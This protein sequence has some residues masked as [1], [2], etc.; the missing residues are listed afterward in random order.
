MAKNQIIGKVIA[1]S[2]RQTIQ[3]K[4][5]TKQPVVK[6]QLYMDCTRFDPYT[7]ERGY[8]N[9][10]LLEFANRALEKL[11]ALGLNKGDVVTVT[12]DIQG[13]R[14]KD[15]TGKP[16]IFTRV[17]PYDIELTRRN[18]QPAAPQ[19]QAPLPEPPVKEHV[20]SNGEALIF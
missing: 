5:T 6:R 8:E 19:A 16:Q 13:D 3:S 1:V 14:Y 9:T 12:F 17:R 15:A 10:P 18:D 20:D 7:G 11:E 4:D 2:E